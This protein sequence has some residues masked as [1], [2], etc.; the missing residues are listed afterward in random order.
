MGKDPRPQDPNKNG[1]V[2]RLGFSPY[3]NVGVETFL[4]VFWVQGRGPEADAS[5]WRSLETVIPSVANDRLNLLILFLLYILIS[6]SF[7]WDKSGKHW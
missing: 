2:W 5:A 1:E 7:F 4:S 6:I 3:V